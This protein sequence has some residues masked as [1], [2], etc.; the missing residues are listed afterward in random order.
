MPPRGKSASPAPPLAVDFQH[1]IAA[2]AS[3][4]R[5]R[6]GVHKGYHVLPRVRESPRRACEKVS[7]NE[8][9]VLAIDLARARRAGRVDTTV[10]AASRSSSALT[11]LTCRPEG[12]A[13]MN[14]EPLIASP[15]RRCA[16][17]VV[18]F[19]PLP[20]APSYAHSRFALVAHLLDQD[21]HLHRAHLADTDFEPRVLLGFSSASGSQ[22]L[23]RR[24]WQHPHLGEVRARREAPRRRRF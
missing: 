19:L 7:A 3:A 10:Q 20:C 5:S 23:A 22:A 11:R 12:A 8:M 24:P 4:P 18:R 9:V 13:T 17:E 1:D 6:F 21:F 15:R 2:A 16:L 14:S